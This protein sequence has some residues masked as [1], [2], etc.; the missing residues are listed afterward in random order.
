MGLTGAFSGHIFGLGA[1][2]AVVATATAVFSWPAAAAA[3]S[4]S[5]GGRQLLV[6]SFL[7]GAVALG[8]GCRSELEQGN[9][10]FT[11]FA[12]KKAVCFEPD[13]DWIQ[14]PYGCSG[15]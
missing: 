10:F 8:V 4:L 2:A 6:V 7:T 14:I 1:A 9:K 11:P 5:A 13:P 3:A 12:Y 15:S